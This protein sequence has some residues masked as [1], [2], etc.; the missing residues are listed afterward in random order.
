MVQVV[1]NWSEVRG[2][3]EEVARAGQDGLDLRLR[4]AAVEPVPGFPNL[5]AEAPG[6]SITVRL[7]LDDVGPTPEAGET[8]RC[9]VRKT[10]PDRYFARPGS[11]SVLPPAGS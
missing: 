9:L 4:V 11:C 7:P 2:R 1:E 10:G 5:L 6:Q 8:V 3:V